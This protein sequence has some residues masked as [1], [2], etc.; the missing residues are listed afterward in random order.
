M[1]IGPKAMTR[2]QSPVPS[3]LL[4]VAQSTSAILEGRVA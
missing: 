4:P 1:K 3:Q 2:T